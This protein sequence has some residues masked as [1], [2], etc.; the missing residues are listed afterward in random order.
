MFG[1]LIQNNGGIEPDVNNRINAG[2]M[3]WWRASGITC[4]PDIS[5][6]FNGKFYKP[7]RNT[8]IDLNT[9]KQKGWF[10]NL[11]NHIKG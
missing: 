9:E 11:I 10:I 5:L 6:K 8:G 1:L 4:D 2:Y 3:K 7:W